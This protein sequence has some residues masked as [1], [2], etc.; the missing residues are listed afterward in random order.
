MLGKNEDFSF[1]MASVITVSRTT[2]Q[3]LRETSM[4]ELCMRYGQTS[5][6]INNV[7]LYSAFHI[8]SFM[9]AV[10]WKDKLSVQLE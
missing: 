9:V 2:S 4:M 1:K 10:L 8:P 3:Q 7:T 5:K 6:H